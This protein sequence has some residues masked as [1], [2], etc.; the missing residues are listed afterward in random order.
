MTYHSIRCVGAC[1]LVGLVV[2]G[3]TS[4]G[5]SGLP[6]DR[7]V[8]EF[9][10][11]D[12]EVFCSWW[13]DTLGGETELPCDTGDSVAYLL[14][15]VE[16]CTTGFEGLPSECSWSVGSL[17]LCAYATAEDACAVFLEEVCQRPMDCSR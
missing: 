2:C 1:V 7:R 13:V 5:D 17:E 3:C 16:A 8:G 14:V 4:A 12:R 11:S 15:N 6:S 10:S 9:S